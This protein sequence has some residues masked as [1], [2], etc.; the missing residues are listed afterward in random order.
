MNEHTLS[1]SI[2]LF[3]IACCCECSA[4]KIKIWK[5]TKTKLMTRNWKLYTIIKVEKNVTHKIHKH[6]HWSLLYVYGGTYKYLCK[7]QLTII[8][9]LSVLLPLKK[10]VS[11]RKC[12]SSFF[13]SC[14]FCLTVF[15]IM[16]FD[17][18]I[19]M[20]NN[21]KIRREIWQEQ[22]SHMKKSKCIKK[23]ANIAQY[24]N[25]LFDSF[26]SPFSFFYSWPIYR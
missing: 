3:N 26:N 9:R 22:R 15:F 21:E 23:H 5:P 10:K 4:V 20:N 6:T 16:R 8:A 11:M 25:L 12:F 19:K 14:L 2:L 1:L 17:K 13:F 7:I 24:K 18:V